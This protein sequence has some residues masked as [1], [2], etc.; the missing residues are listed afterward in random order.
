MF[1][2]PKDLYCDV[3]IERV[4][5]TNI[6]YFKGE[7]EQNNE[8]NYCGAFIR[9]FDGDRWYYSSISDEKNIQREINKL[10]LMAKKNTHIY[11]NPIVQKFS[12]NRAEVIRYEG[13]SVKNVPNDRKDNYLKKYFDTI[14]QYKEVSSWGAKYID[15]YVIREFYSSK[16]AS[17]K[18]DNN[19]FGVAVRLTLTYEKEV[20]NHGW[21]KSLKSFE[22]LEEN[23]EELKD[24]IEEGINFV[25]NAKPIEPGEYTA[26]LAPIVAGVFAH[27]SFG[28]KS[29]ADFMVGDEGMK[30]EWQIGKQV[31][32]S[33]LSIVDYG[34]IEGSGYTPFDDEGNKCTKTYLIKEGKLAGRLHDSS[35]AAILEDEVT[36]N[37]RAINFQ[38]EPIPRM[39]NTYIEKGDKTFEEL[40]GEIKDGIYIKDI[41][42]GSGMSTFTLAPSISYRIR[43]GKLA[44]PLKIAVAT[45]TVFETLN[46]IDG[47]SDEIELFAFL[48]GG[49]G[50]MEQWPLPVGFGGP[51]VRV[52]KLFV[53]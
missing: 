9:V 26:V 51:Y 16:G 38:F 19:V 18:Y 42:H 37:G 30:A 44:E 45:G 22:D 50:K 32:S 6:A 15:R 36:G 33:I 1:D 20:F 39:T 8:E 10:S 35:T 48:T 7:L 40:V 49:C 27:E 17:V 5:K 29:E 24:A 12:V 2:F 4:F 43:D 46:L 34:N 53:Q 52:K 14:E 41:N 13:E 47:L 25:K 21:Q 31:G 11:E 3:R 23:K 28:H